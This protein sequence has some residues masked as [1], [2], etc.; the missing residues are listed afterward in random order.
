MNKLIDRMSN[1]QKLRTR[2]CRIDGNRTVSFFLGRDGSTHQEKASLKI[3]PSNGHWWPS[4]WLPLR[5]VIHS[6]FPVDH[7]QK[8]PENRWKST[9]SFHQSL[10]FLWFSGPAEIG[11]LPLDIIKTRLV[12]LLNEIERHQV[13]PSQKIRSA[14]DVKAA[15]FFQ[16]SIKKCLKTFFLKKSSNFKEV[17]SLNTQKHL[18]RPP[19]TWRHYQQRK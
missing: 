13:W 6:A 15:I 7:V 17:A 5:W 19:V 11:G 8:P 1:G 12:L 18:I 16:V 14:S 2:K 9:N 3:S 4:D 10:H